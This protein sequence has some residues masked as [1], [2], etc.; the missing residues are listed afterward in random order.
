[1]YK[2]EHKKMR[3]IRI[4]KLIEHSIFGTMSDNECLHQLYFLWVLSLNRSRKILYFP[5]TCDLFFLLNDC[6][7]PSSLVNVIKFY[8]R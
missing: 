3:K 6:L 1:M 2:D 7:L 5:K 4:A 8:V